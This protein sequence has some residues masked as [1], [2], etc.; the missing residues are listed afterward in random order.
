MKANA[1][2]LARRVELVATIT[3]ADGSVEHLGAIARWHRNPL[4][5][6]W[7]AITSKFGA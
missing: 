1:T 3:R 2:V 7:W 4:V 6:L 5:R